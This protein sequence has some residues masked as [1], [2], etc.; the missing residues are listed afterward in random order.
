[1]RRRDA[2][3]LLYTTFA[4]V[5]H[6]KQYSGVINVNLILVKIV[7]YGWKNLYFNLLKKDPSV[8]SARQG[9]FGTAE[10][11]TG[12]MVVFTGGGLPRCSSFDREIA[13]C[14]TRR[15]SVIKCTA[16]I[17]LFRLNL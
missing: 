6:T 2:T 8:T 3:G 13:P 4:K 16:V 11:M 1:M 7:R 17:Q 9:C 14:G 12:I 5:N 15:Q 10:S